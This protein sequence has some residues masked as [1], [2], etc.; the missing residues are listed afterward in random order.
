MQEKLFI[1]T[2]KSMGRC[3]LGFSICCLPWMFY[4]SISSQLLKSV[5]DPKASISSLFL[6]MERYHSVFAG[7]DRLFQPKKLASARP[8]LSIFN[9]PSTRDSKYPSPIL[10]N[11][12]PPSQ[13]ATTTFSSKAPTQSLQKPHTKQPPTQPPTPSPESPQ[14]HSQTPSRPY[15]WR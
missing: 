14:H 9:N 7:T 10:H 8:W 12:K 13:P 11:L 3:R 1:L 5:A 4:R 2:I 15:A 6:K